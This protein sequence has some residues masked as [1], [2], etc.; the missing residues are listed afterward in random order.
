VY[1]RKIRRKKDGKDH[2]Y[3]ALVESVRTGSRVR[4]RTVCYLG[5]VDEEETR[6]LGRMA[7]GLDGA[8]CATRDLFE[9][10]LPRTVEVVADRV[11][12][13]RIRDFGDAFAGLS[14]WRHL[15]LDAFFAER[16]GPGRESVAWPA[17]IAYAAV[18]RF[19]EASSDLAVAESFTD[20][21]ALADLLGFDPMRVNDDRLYRTLDAAVG[22]KEALAAHLR[23]A[24][25]GLFAVRY[26]LLLYDL[27]SV[28]FEGKMEGNA[29]AQHGHSRDGRPDCKQV[30]VGLVVTREGLPLDYEVF[31]GN[32]NDM[33]TLREVV[34][35]VEGKLGR[36]ERIWVSDRGLAS[37]AN[38]AWL[39]GRGD[40]YLVGTPKAM[41]KRFE[42]QMLEGSWREVR[43]GLDVQFAQAPDGAG[44]TFVLCRSAD[45]RQKELAMVGRFAGR[46]E[47]GL[48]KLRKACEGTRPRLK[49]PVVAGRRL[50][51]LLKTNSRVA[52]LFDIRVEQAA[53]GRLAVQ[54]KRKA[55]TG[56]SWAERSAGH[57][58]LRTNVVVQLTPEELWRAY[59]LLTQ[60]EEAFR[61]YKSGLDVRPIYH[62]KPGRV[63]GHL[64][65]CFLALVMLKTFEMELERRGLGRSPHKVLAELRTLRSMDVILPTTDGRELRRRIVSE[66]EPALRILL[67]RMAWRA[68]K[69]LA[70]RANVVEKM[71]PDLQKPQQIERFTA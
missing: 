28:Y 69:R 33:T 6:P 37:E 60:A 10:A 19:C 32:R 38:L 53:R 35:A 8:P 71:A 23:R 43:E 7:R 40:L 47:A 46:I 49:D 52:A 22:H 21:S 13:E 41:L 11:R 18:A 64:F 63:H 25:A 50:G 51:A 70:G 9:E 36:A 2:V 24:Y 57:Y 68:P 17:M 39:R 1:L 54:W 20:R 5:D 27:T 48:E 44:E 62:H 42:R 58:V 14:L 31:A 16:Q 26:D 30:V 66:P 55:P 34:E 3:W 59:T 45:R 65:I 56:E 12:T 29:E 15:G 61:Q 4:Q 67:Q